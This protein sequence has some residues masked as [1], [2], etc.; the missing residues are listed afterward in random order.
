MFQRA[1]QETRVGNS[2]EKY[3]TVE[4]GL[5]KILEKIR[6]RVWGTSRKRETLTLDAVEDAQRKEIYVRFLK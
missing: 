1:I 4:V 3:L 6:K 2:K 5:G